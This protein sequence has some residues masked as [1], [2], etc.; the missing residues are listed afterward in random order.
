MI[1]LNI[2][3]PLHSF[4]SISLYEQLDHFH[5]S[6]LS[7]LFSLVTY[8]SHDIDQNSILQKN[9]LAL[10]YFQRSLKINEE[11]GSILY[12]SK[13]MIMIGAIYKRQGDYTLAIDY[14]QR[15]LQITEETKM[16]KHELS[17]TLH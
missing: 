14:F 9:L 11:I 16:S 4:D 17:F 5:A 6:I 12:A 7:F 2:L 13:D 10:D 3:F 1:R 15:A 8:N